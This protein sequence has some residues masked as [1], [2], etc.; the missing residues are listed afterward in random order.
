MVQ[1]GEGDLGARLDCVYAALRH[2]GAPAVALLGADA[3]QLSPKH[4]AEAGF[5]ALEAGAN[6]VIGPAT[7]GGFY[8]FAGK[9]PDSPGRLDQR[10]LQRSGY[11]RASG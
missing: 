1:Q 11:R 5:L 8:L 9:A 2:G 3:P 7:D 4:L 10:T 6:F